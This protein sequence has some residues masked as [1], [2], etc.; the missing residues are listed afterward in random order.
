MAELLPESN[1]DMV[2]LNLVHHAII[3]E[4]NARG[5]SL[6]RLFDRMAKMAHDIGDDFRLAK[7]DWD[8]FVNIG[9]DQSE[10]QA[11]VNRQAQTLGDTWAKG[12]MLC[13]MAKHLYELLEE[14]CLDHPAVSQIE[15]VNYAD[16]GTLE[17]WKARR[18]A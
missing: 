7:I 15:R 10:T 5:E 6:A 16:D 11:V 3:E 8:E 17:S 4:V 18:K 12:W 9:F 1:A 2:A 14:R 13:M